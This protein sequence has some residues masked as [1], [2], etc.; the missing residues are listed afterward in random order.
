MIIMFPNPTPSL[1]IRDDW[2]MLFWCLKAENG[3]FTPALICF[4]KKLHQCQHIC[5]LKSI[6]R[7]NGHLTQ[8]S[9]GFFIHCSSKVW[10]K[11]KQF[12]LYFTPICST[13][14]SYHNLSSVPHKYHISVKVCT[15]RDHS[16]SLSKASAVKRGVCSMSAVSTWKVIR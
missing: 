10:S 8:R 14:I 11:K 9:T 6:I 16:L 13:Q 1:S 4:R 15:S 2:S 5:F 12:I 7:Y 3:G